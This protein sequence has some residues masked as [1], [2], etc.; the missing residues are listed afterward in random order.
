MRL[1]FVIAII[2]TSL[3]AMCQRV[4]LRNDSLFIN[5]HYVNGKTSK[6][7]LDSLLNA[8]GK[9]RFIRDRFPK[10]DK[11]LSNLTEITYDK[12]GLIF[13]KY[14]HDSLYISISL[15]LHKNSDP[16][17]DHN[18][19]PT[20]PFKGEL[21]IDSNYMNDKRTIEQ[22]Q[23]L[24]NISIKFQTSTF[25][26]RNSIIMAYLFYQKKA[27]GLC[28]IIKQVQLPSFLFIRTL[29]FAMAIF[30]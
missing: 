30:C 27:S 11:M 12:E 18:N 9:T 23:D 17:V 3:F 25:L 19:M 4:D 16:G 26:G 24:N 13:S 6:S 29:S 8:K 20:K 15:K 22:L 5:Y 2:Q 14:E 21:Y 10:D 28:L 7:T 1:F